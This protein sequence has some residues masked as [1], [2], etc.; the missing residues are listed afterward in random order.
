MDVINIAKT[1]RETFEDKNID[2]NLLAKLYSAYTNVPDIESF[3]DKSTDM[4]PKLSCGVATVY[5]KNALKDGEII[6]G[7][8]GNNDHTFLLVD[9]QI[10]DITA[11][12]YGGPRV[13]VG[14]LKVRW[15]KK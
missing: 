2:K 5:L 8:Y 11:D 4:F 15:T 14:E 10:V 9:N 1:T 7:R 13:Y 3:I 12:Q 6:K